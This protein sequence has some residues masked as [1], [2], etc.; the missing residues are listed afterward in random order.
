MSGAAVP[1]RDGEAQRRWHFSKETWIALAAILGIAVYLVARFLFHL[2]PGIS[3]WSLIAVLVAGTP[4]LFDL[5]KK[6]IALEVGSDA[7]AGISIITSAILGEYLAGA[8]IVLMLAGGTALELYATHRASAVL[9]AL[10]KRLPSEAHR[11]TASGIVDVLTADVQ[12]AD[13]WWCCRMRSAPR[14]ER[15]SKVTAR[16]TSRT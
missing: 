4:L 11:L 6:L 16:W 8:I 5:L 3:D 14:T 2:P 13:P 10:A 15:W 9:S 1:S 12:I 7:L